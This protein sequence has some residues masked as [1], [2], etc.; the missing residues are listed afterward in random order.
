MA[1]SFLKYAR[2]ATRFGINVVPGYCGEKFSRIPGWPALAT[3][4]DMR[5]VEWND[6]DESYNVIAVSKRG[7]TCSIDID[8]PLVIDKLPQPL[9]DTL[10]VDTPSGG[11][12]AHFLATPASDKLGNCNILRI[13][14]YC[15]PDKDGDLTTLLELKVHDLTVAAPG[16]FNAAEVQYKPRT[17][18]PESLLPFPEW[19]ADFFAEHRH[20]PMIGSGGTYRK[21][22]P[23]FES[24]D[25]FDWYEK[26]KAFT[27]EDPIAK[28]GFDLRMASHGCIFKGDFHS[29]SQRSGFRVYP[30]GGVDYGCFATSCEGN[31][32]ASL[33]QV[34]DF[35]ETEGYERYPYCI[36][37]DEDDEVF[38]ADVD[39]DEL[40]SEEE[41]IVVAEPI[42]LEAEPVEVLA[43][44]VEE[45]APEPEEEAAPEP[46]PV[47]K[48][49]PKPEP[50]EPKK[51]KDGDIDMLAESILN[52]LLRDPEAIFSN[53]ALYRKRFNGRMHEVEYPPLCN[54][55]RLLL[56]YVTELNKLPSKDELVDFVTNHRVNKQEDCK[57]EVVQ[58]LGRLRDSDFTLTLDTTMQRFIDRVDLKAEA[59]AWKAGYGI[60]KSS[61]DIP[62]ARALLR[63]QWSTSAALSGDHG[64]KPGAIQDQDHI[65]A[66]KVSF[67]RYLLGA[68]DGRRFATGFPSIDLS[69]LR[70]GLDNEHAI[71]YFGPSNN[72][73]TS[74][75]LSTAYN[76]A[77]QGKNGLV[78]VGEHQAEK[79]EES[80]AMLH[81]QLP[82][83]RKRFTIPPI[84]R[85]QS[86]N[87]AFKPT[88][89]D[90]ANMH[91][92]LT[93][94]GS[95]KN[96]PGF[97]EV[98]NI[99]S[100]GGTLG[101]I[102]SY[103]ES[104][105]KKY[106]WDYF[107]IDPF[108]SV[109]SEE[110]KA[111]NNNSWAAGKEAVDS[112]FNYS[113][114]F[115]G[116]RGI[117]VM[118][119]AQMLSKPAREVEAIQAEDEEDVQGLISI[120]KQDK[121]IQLFTTIVQ[122]FD[123]AFGVALTKKKGREGLLVQGRTRGGSDF[124]YL[125]FRLDRDSWYALEANP[126][127][128]EPSLD[129]LE[130]IE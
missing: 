103:L 32:N 123:C 93:D 116:G 20:V 100:I 45:T 19:L 48:V 29:Q 37:E 75:I 22:H 4:N 58:Y 40:E 55:L 66:L 122:R 102:Y 42:I 86:T 6:K 49:E 12:H 112:I 94:L 33:E 108:D 111:D 24:E 91:E 124:D 120:L 34:M 44:A 9:P 15:V 78:F 52:I 25:W 74:V 8:D 114:D 128:Q 101:S 79:V 50:E 96:V 127:I 36:Y 119:T 104:S 5:L 87:K 126:P 76:F 23:D 61:G 53:F 31:P 43:P 125:R 113:R 65:D 99:N 84:A 105:H 46:E 54:A 16:S 41:K 73:K 129:G 67:Q 117:L 18:Y 21:V 59:R 121:S 35:L 110:V 68:D 72:A 60:L 57:L 83:F 85:W 51:L 95:M 92:V 39:I 64:Y 3:T 98:K 115:D 10:L 71:V 118:V 107:V 28:S 90:L 82:V 2:W 11:L 17:P 81:S 106:N 30:D 77:K 14:D 63:E 7:A 109:I 38:L 80:L 27:I 56:G 89:L 130:F 70:I 13:G 47:V 1:Y 88:A 62:A 97:L 69:S 26:K